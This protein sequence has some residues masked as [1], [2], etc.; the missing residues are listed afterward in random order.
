MPLVRR[1][2]LALVTAS[3]FA[4]AC[5]LVSSTAGSPKERVY[6]VSAGAGTITALSAETGQLVEGPI[7]VGP[8]PRSVAIGPSGTLLVLSVPLT[9]GPAPQLAHLTRAGRGWSSRR[10]T[11]PE[12]MDQPILSGA[13]GRY[14]SLLYRRTPFRSGAA[15][16]RVALLDVE[17][18][19]VVRVHDACLPGEHA[20]A[21][22]HSSSVA[23]SGGL[24][25]LAIW[26]GGDRVVHQAASPARPNDDHRLVTLDLDTGAETARR[27]LTGTTSWIHEAPAAMHLAAAVWTPALHADAAESHTLVLTLPALELVTTTPLAVPLS[28]ATLT[29]DGAFVYGLDPSGEHLYRVD[30]LGGTQSHV[31]ALPS[32]ASALAAAGTSIFVAL[33]RYN[34]VNVYGGAANDHHH[35]VTV[36]A[37]PISFTVSAAL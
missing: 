20:T 23:R 35:T 26:S 11:L 18:G 30:L 33:P 9:P 14:A 27:R 7:L 25:H 8:T 6:V 24:A 19:A 29:A 32:P 28:R 1:R 10:V 36:G 37:H 34:K 13:G 5:R 22:A 4:G 12:P 16:F 31:T 2:A 21:V 3:A 15:P 17:R